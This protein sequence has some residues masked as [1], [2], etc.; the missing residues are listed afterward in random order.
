MRLRQVW[1]GSLVPGKCALVRPLPGSGLLVL[2]LPRVV[3]REQ[4]PR[5]WTR[6]TT[7]LSP[8]SF[9]LEIQ[10]HG[11]AGTL[12][13]ARIGLC[14]PCRVSVAPTRD[15]TRHRYS[16]VLCRSYP[17][18]PLLRRCRCGCGCGCGCESSG[19]ILSVVVGG[20]A[21]SGSETPWLVHGS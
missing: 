10:Q 8:T 18:P 6:T 14:S 17:P 1:A 21:K 13:R 15:T 16:K 3:E 11:D 12:A 7:L 20:T 9:G 2:P 5:T 19:C 4:D